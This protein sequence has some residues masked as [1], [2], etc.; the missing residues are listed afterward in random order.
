MQTGT[1][2][3]PPRDNHNGEGRTRTIMVTI[4]APETAALGVETGSNL[5]GN[6][7]E[8]EQA[9]NDDGTMARTRPLT[10][11]CELLLVEWKQA[12]MTTGRGSGSTKGTLM[13]TIARQQ[14]QQ[15]GVTA[16]ASR[17]PPHILREGGFFF[18]G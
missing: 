5:A 8:K 11:C 10:P 9:N 12:A 6:N 14:R 3:Q 4:T 15:D 7:G 18:F 13:A 1:T 16:A 2:Q 17:P